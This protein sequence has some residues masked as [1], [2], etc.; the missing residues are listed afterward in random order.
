MRDNPSL[1]HAAATGL[2]VIPLFIVDTDLV[3]GIRSDGAVFDFQAECL[4]DLADGI[5]GLGGK[6][7]LRKG[8]LTEVFERIIGETHPGSVYF[9][10]DYEPAA[11]DRDLA[12]TKFLGRLGIEV[13]SF[14]DVVIHAPEEI[15]TSGGGPYSV[16]TP[17]AAKWRRLPKPSPLGKPSRISTPRLASDP[18]PGGKELG[19][20]RHI[21]TPF[22]S[23]GETNA[24]KRW[25][26]FLRERLRSYS[27][28]RDL[29]YVH[30][31]SKMSP[32]LRF[33]CISPARMYWDLAEM[34][35]SSGRHPP[36]SAEKFVDELIW[37]EFYTH[38]LYYFPYTA[39][40]NFRSQFDRLR[41]SFDEA[42]FEAWK[43][44]KTGFPL[45]DAGMRQLNATGWM[46]NR[47]R[48][49]TASF[50]TKDLFIDWRRGEEYFAAK[51]LDIEKASN[52]GGWQWS[53]STGVDPRPL[54]IFNPV[55]QSRRF[56]PDGMYIK[57][58]VPELRNVPARYI[59]EPARMS[60][61][62]QEETGLTAGKDYP[63]PIV[64]HRKSAEHF[65]GQYVK[66]KSGHRRTGSFR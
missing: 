3:K 35:L 13:K 49:V 2:P 55:I 15:R 22:V 14:D 46:H 9:N 24:S 23:G 27:D 48:M 12:A 10:M 66:A 39:E 62:L 63:F 58:W 1:F 20:E 18:I 60:P 32:Y 37:R 45:V 51:L 7:I 34:S 26:S 40:R 21:V 38:V 16:F 33:G 31:T 44:G 6:L 36:V 61:A 29:P 19:R 47:V 8:K 43:D 50:L 52:V 59:H 57:E 11:M 65:K 30:G 64:D 25:D 53:A 42:A 5:E 4:R 17:F 41:W 28:T 54:R 56:D